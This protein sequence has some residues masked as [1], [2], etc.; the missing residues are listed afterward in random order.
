MAYSST[1]QA[2]GPLGGGLMFKIYTATDVAT[3][4]TSTI[5]TDFRKILVAVPMNTTR[6]ASGGL[7]I[8]KSGG[9]LT[10]TA[11]TANDDFEILVIGV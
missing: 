10:L 3:D 1:E 7:K 4:G 9:T 11:E 2:Q 6:A 5:S 8:A